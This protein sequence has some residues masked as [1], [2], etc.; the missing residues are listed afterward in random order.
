M[1]REA[2]AAAEAAMAP[3]ATPPLPVPGGGTRA[4][5][6]AAAAPG[7][8]IIV[9]PHGNEPGL[10]AVA[11]TPAAADA[12]AGLLIPVQGVGAQALID[13]FSQARGSDRVHDAIDIPAAAGTPVLAAADGEVVKLFESKLGGTTLYQFDPSGRFVYYYAHLQGYAP[14]I[15]E[16][17]QLKR[18][19][20]LGYVGSSGNADAQAP[21]LHFAVG[22][23]G[24]EKNWWE[25]TALNPYPLLGGR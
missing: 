12:P 7:A 2:R 23:L 1:Q 11:E 24:A 19:E 10:G 18:G 17:K 22:V 6:A 20:V 3:P 13:T 25:Y 5:S 21:H 16:G 4:P 8:Q 15:V 14:G 9:D